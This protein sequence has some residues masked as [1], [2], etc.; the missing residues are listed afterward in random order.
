MH[1]LILAFPYIVRHLLSTSNYVTLMKILTG[2]TKF[3]FV[4]ASDVNCI[5]VFW[6][7]SLHC[8]QCLEAVYSI[9][10]KFFKIYHLLL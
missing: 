3:K 7:L 4:T 9:N 2:F 6:F 8:F 10:H 1:S 5:H